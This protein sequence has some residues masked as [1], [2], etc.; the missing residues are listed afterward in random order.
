MTRATRLLVAFSLAIVSLAACK[1]QRDDQQNAAP[2][3][4]AKTDQVPATGGADFV[5]T[6]D[7]VV[8][9]M[10]TKLAELDTKLASLKRDVNARSAELTFEGKAALD[11][12]IAKLEEQR[13]AA[14]RT[15][16][17][18]RASTAEQWEQVKQRTDEALK[19]VEDAYQA[20]ASKLRR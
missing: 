18:T 10:Q 20:A 12:A 5:Q 15:V 13:M 7:R 6:R 1:S 14:Q 8:Q 4:S 9:E 3:K 11:D 17:Q 19:N 16:E 2:S